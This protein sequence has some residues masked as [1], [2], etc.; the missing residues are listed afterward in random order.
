M[1]I[2]LRT[3]D[4]MRI[5]TLYERALPGTR[6]RLLAVN[7]SRTSA[8]APANIAV[9][10]S[11]DVALEAAASWLHDVFAG[12]RH[13]LTLGGSTLPIERAAILAALREHAAR[14]VWHP[15]QAGARS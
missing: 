11:A 14:Y 3:Q 6:I 13:E 9:E 4:L 1:E 15:R 8:R 10:I 12:S 7:G 5:L 2:E